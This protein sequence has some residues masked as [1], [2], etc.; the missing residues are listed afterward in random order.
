MKYHVTVRF[1]IILHILFVIYFLNH[2]FSFVKLLTHNI[3]NGFKV[4]AS[5]PRQS[6]NAILRLKNDVEKRREKGF[7]AE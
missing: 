5:M 1:I 4:D 3:Q 2:I 6:A 7:E